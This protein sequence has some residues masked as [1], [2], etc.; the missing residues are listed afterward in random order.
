VSLVGWWLIYG[1]VAAAPIAAL[2]TLATG[3]GPRRGR[4]A[5]PPA[6]VLE[7]PVLAM[8]AGGPGRVVDAVVVD[9]METG[10][11]ASRHG[12]LSLAGSDGPTGFR[13]RAQD[14]I[15]NTVAVVGPADVVTVR[16][17]ACKINIAFEIEFNELARLGLVAGAL[18]RDL[19]S[20]GWGLG[21]FVPLFAVVI[22]ML[23][24]Q[25][26]AAQ[27]SAVVAFGLIFVLPPLTV[28]LARL[29]PGYHGQDPR[30]AAGHA[31]LGRITATVDDATGQAV[32]VALG[33]FAGMTDQSMRANVQGSA[34][35][36]RW[37]GSGHRTGSTAE[38]LARR[39]VSRPTGADIR[40]NG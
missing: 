10:R 33:G 15:G 9:L 3:L 19:V 26:P 28:V 7:I 18:R 8:L 25:S 16:E 11:I 34:P 12:V 20:I 21:T 29:R 22:A 24:D 40:D 6:E 27:G 13:L 17:R 2:T 30:T 37:I 31:L 38:T 14:V 32:R 39:L 36:S 23:L 1:L 5:S 4:P 35:D